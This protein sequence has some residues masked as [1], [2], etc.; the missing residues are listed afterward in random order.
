MLEP[1]IEEDSFGNGGVKP[2]GEDGSVD[3]EGAHRPSPP[4]VDLRTP[5]R[6]LRSRDW[7][8]RDQRHHPAPRPRTGHHPPAETHFTAAG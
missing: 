8:S 2:S 3:I 1:A 4:G 7:A 6:D 5:P